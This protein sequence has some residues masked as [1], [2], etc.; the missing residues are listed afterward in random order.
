MTNEELKDKLTKLGS[1]ILEIRDQLKNSQF[2]EQSDELSIAYLYVASAYIKM[3][4]LNR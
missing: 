3:P 2:T 1:E 4:I